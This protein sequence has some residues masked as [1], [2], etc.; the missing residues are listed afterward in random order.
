MREFDGR[1]AVVT[2]GASGIGFSLA[3]AFAAEGANIVIG[4]I[5]APALDEAV[6][7]LE[8]S[9]A[10]VIGLV[11]DVSDAAQVQALADAAVER[12]G[13][14]HIACNNAGV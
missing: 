7:K 8:A 2:G 3:S 4:D 11:T 10:K 6:G 12:F 14:I 1:V 9:G 13:A 5:E